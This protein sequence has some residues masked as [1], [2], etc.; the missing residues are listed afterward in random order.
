[1]L[2]LLAYVKPFVIV[3][4]SVILFLGIIARTIHTVIH[5]K[6]RQTFFLYLSLHIIFLLVILSPVSF[7]HIYV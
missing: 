7:T 1:M 4:S 6:H 3:L 2:E 5:P